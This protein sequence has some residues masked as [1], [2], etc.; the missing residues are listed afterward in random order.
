MMRS[1][2][3]VSAKLSRLTS[4][5]EA[6]SG[7]DGCQNDEM[8]CGWKRGGCRAKMVCQRLNKIFERCAGLFLLQ[9]N[10]R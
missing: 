1:A 10:G 4:S 8:N 5:D 2:G 7:S 6:S 9:G 3:K